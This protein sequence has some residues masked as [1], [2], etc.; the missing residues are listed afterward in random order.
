M[1]SGAGKELEMM[2]CQRA[3][4][5]LVILVLFAFSCATPA[6][7]PRFEAVAHRDRAATLVELKE[8]WTNYS[9][10]YG[11]GSVGLASAVIFDPK[12]D[13][14]HLVG[15]RYVKVE[16]EETLETVISVIQSYVTFT[17]T[18]YSIY[19]AQG[20]FFGFVFTAH[21]RPFPGKV[22]DKTLILPN[23]KSPSYIGGP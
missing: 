3:C 5:L 10:S 7:A 19:G 8:N 13:G 11:G 9:I 4:L 23:W 12:D 2:R 16:D 21:Y 18:L 6:G 20:E 15:A 22:D 1:F 17:P 14:R